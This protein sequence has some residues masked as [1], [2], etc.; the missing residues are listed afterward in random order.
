MAT[1]HA[2]SARDEITVAPIIRAGCR[3]QPGKRPSLTARMQFVLISSC[4]LAALRIALYLR[5]HESFALCCHADYCEV[6]GIASNPIDNSLSPSEGERV[7]E[8]G[9]LQILDLAIF[10][11]G[12]DFP[13]SP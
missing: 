8:R 5:V 10:N 11:T 7:R 2:K 4:T 9:G 13:L 6:N 3:S 12:A 1:T